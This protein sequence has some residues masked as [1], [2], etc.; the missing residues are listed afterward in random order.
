MSFDGKHFLKNTDVFIGSGGTMTA[1]SAFWEFQQSH[2]MQFQIEIENYLMK[3]Y[4]IKRNK[5]QIKF[6]IILRKILKIK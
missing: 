4:L 6:L 1:E 5:I 3:K 2:I